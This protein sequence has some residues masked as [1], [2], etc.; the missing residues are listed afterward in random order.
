MSLMTT[1]CMLVIGWLAV[2]AA[3][4]WGVLRIA[5]RHHH[6]LPSTTVTPRDKTAGRPATAH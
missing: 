2:A 4:L 5:R 6:P 1:I 3:M